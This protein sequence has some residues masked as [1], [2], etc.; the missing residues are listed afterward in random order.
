MHRCKETEDIE[1]AAAVHFTLTGL[2]VLGWAILNLLAA[3]LFTNGL[4]V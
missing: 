4:L 1:Q 3:I 2:F